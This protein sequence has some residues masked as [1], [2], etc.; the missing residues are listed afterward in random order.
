MKRS[1][2]Q[3][4][5]L[6]W[7]PFGGYPTERRCPNCDYSHQEGRCAA[8]NK[9]CFK[10]NR[11]GHFQKCCKS[12]KKSSLN[13]MSNPTPKG[14]HP[15]E[16][17]MDRFCGSLDKRDHALARSALKFFVNGT[18]CEGLLD[19]GA[20]DNFMDIKIARKLKLK[21]D[22]GL[23]STITL[24]NKKC[25]TRTLGIVTANVKIGNMDFM[26]NRVKFTLMD[27]FW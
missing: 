14:A 11:I 17:G 9:K 10:C 25:K 19:T 22:S 5:G 13:V 21:I 16:L 8:K 23:K 1:S 2:G 12:N 3:S 20:S 24:A 6:N 4:G 18:F 7:K 15:G 27:T 26:Y